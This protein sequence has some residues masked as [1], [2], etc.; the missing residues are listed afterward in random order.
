MDKSITHVQMRWKKAFNHISSNSG[1][2][3]IT[4]AN[5]REIGLELFKKIVFIDK[6]QNFMKV[7]ILLVDREC[8]QTYYCSQYFDTW[9]HWAGEFIETY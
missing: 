7:T 9:H 3:S 6:Q 5:D 8:K 2:K 1:G 4:I